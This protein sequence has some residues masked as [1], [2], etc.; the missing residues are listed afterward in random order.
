M[1]RAHHLSLLKS[2]VAA[3]CISAISCFAYAEKSDAATPQTLLHDKVQQLISQKVED[4]EFA[5]VI[6]GVSDGQH[7]QFAG[8]GAKG[9]PVPDKNSIYEIGSLTKT[10]TA[11][12]LAKQIQQGRIQAA[13]PV[14]ELAPECMP[15][16]SAG[17]SIS[18]LD[19]ATHTSGLPRLPENLQPK[20]MANPY[21]DYTQKDL[22]SY[23]QTIKNLPGKG[24][25]DY[26]NLGYGMLGCALAAVSEKP[27]EQLIREEISKPFSM[28]STGIQLSAEMQK[29]LQGGHDASGKPVSGWDF[30]AM[31]A[32]GAV[33][34][35]ATDMLR[36]LD[37]LM[38]AARTDQASAEKLVQTAQRDT[39][40]PKTRIAFGWHLSNMYGRDMVWH[41]GMTGGYAS[42][43]AFSAD[44]KLGVIVL[45][46]TAR[47]PEALGIAALFPQQLPERKAVRLSAEAL[48]QFSGRYALTSAF[49]ITVTPGN[50]S[51][52]IQAS[53]QP[54][55]RAAVIAEDS[56]EIPEV[57]AVI[58]FQR[59]ADGRI[60][61][62][63]LQQ[64]GQ[65][66]PGKKL[67]D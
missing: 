3:V 30:D 29:R 60:S 43:A 57:G 55:F 66:I 52:T 19:L 50:N 64:N 51:L 48:Q 20:N 22:N 6:I 33:R 10:M 58:T 39:S 7:H 5:S 24:K 28:P 37:T 31:A 63:T 34:S 62:L 44:G 25:Y 49:I 61:Q 13:H 56:F 35:D 23:I 42:F 47:S 15:V 36:Y 8:F 17:L 67:A 65:R 14:A 45:T 18:W 12:I 4:G 2:T 32:A 16:A 41:N 11:L 46:N 38:A 21:A 53:G 1:Y 59:D 27:F 54:A 9:Q 40:T 26:S